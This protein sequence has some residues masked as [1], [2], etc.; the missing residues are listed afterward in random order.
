[1][2]NSEAAQQT[3]YGYFVTRLE[4]NWSSDGEDDANDGDEL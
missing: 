4:N 2:N 3:A 1:M